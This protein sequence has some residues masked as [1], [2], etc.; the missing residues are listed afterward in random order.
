MYLTYDYCG[1]TSEK[2][3]T[4]INPAPVHYFFFFAGTLVGGFFG[5]SGTPPPVAYSFFCMI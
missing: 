2:A 5:G 4:P 3:P 1:N